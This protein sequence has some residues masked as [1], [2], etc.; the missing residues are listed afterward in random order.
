M[1][2]WLKLYAMYTFSTKPDPCHYTTLLNADFLN[3]YL[4]LDLLQSDCWDLASKWRRH[5]VA[6]TFL[7][8]SHCQTF[9]DCLET[10][11]LYFNRTAPRLITTRHGCFPAATERRE[12]GHCKRYRATGPHRATGPESTW[13]W[14]H[15]QAAL[16]DI[17]PI[18]RPCVT[19]MRREVNRDSGSF[20]KYSDI[21][22]VTISF[23]ACC[24]SHRAT[25]LPVMVHD[26]H[27]RRT[28]PD[29]LQA[30]PTG[31][32]VDGVKSAL[33]PALWPCTFCSDPI[34]LVFPFAHFADVYIFWDDICR[35]LFIFVV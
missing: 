35:F 9:A 29:Y 11:L 26:M 27:T 5:T 17:P 20:A 14:L 21:G 12:N 25:G 8:R 22:L 3:V 13:K 28:R 33:T 18:R 34:L 15:P 1:T 31:P 6:A 24:V 19:T 10:I 23:P 30:C 7:L 16:W 4:T 32:P 2:K